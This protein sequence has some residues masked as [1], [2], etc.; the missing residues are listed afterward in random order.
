LDFPANFVNVFVAHDTTKVPHE[1]DLDAS[2]Q[3]KFKS[4]PLLLSND[5][6]HYHSLKLWKM[7]MVNKCTKEF[8]V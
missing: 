3:W 1:V 7:T 5:A 6:M 2:G 8:F 4:A